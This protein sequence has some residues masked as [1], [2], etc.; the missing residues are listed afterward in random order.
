MTLSMLLLIVGCLAPLASAKPKTNSV[1]ALGK[2]T[3]TYLGN[4]YDG[5][6]LIAAQVKQTPEGIFKGIGI[7]V[8]S[9]VLPDGTKITTKTPL[10]IAI[11]DDGFTLTFDGDVKYFVEPTVVKNKVYIVLSVHFDAEISIKLGGTLRCW[12]QI[13]GYDLQ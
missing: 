9:F 10:A 4:D 2:V 7:S 3:V 5:K 6:M 8:V 1:K 13:E 11:T 12:V